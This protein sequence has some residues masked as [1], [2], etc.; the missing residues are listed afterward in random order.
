MTI[1]SHVLNFNDDCLH[2]NNQS[3]GSH[4]IN[5]TFHLNGIHIAG[6]Q[7]ATRSNRQ[8]QEYSFRLSP[9][10][11][12]KILLTD[13]MN[14]I[15]DIHLL[16]ELN[17]KRQ[18]KIIMAIPIRALSM[19]VLISTGSGVEKLGRFDPSHPAIIFVLYHSNNSSSHYLKHRSVSQHGRRIV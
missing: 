8:R 9:R 16:L 13:E 11:G 2:A 6:Q 12:S 3:K 10:N 19:I 1:P 4:L 7:T 5:R 15:Q 18:Q 17:I 14:R